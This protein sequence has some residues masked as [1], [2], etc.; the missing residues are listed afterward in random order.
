MGKKSKTRQVNHE[1]DSSVSPILELEFDEPIFTTAAHPSK[2]LILTGLATGHLYMSS[3][4]GEALEDAVETRR[5]TIKQGT[6]LKKTW[7]RFNVKDLDEDLVKVQ[8]K[9]KRHKGSCR[10]VAFDST[11]DN[12]Y[13]VGTDKVI[14]RANTETG[15]VIV[16]TDTIDMKQNFTK[17]ILAPNKP[18]V[19]VGSEAG[20]VHVFDTR[21]MKEVHKV[22][23]CHD[24]AVNSL[25]S[26]SAKSDYQYLSVGSTTLTHFDIR[27]GIIQQSED[28]EDEMLSVC[29]VDP[30]K[31]DTA[32]AGMG[33]G[34]VT[35]W[36]G[37][38]NDYV[39]QISRVRLGKDSVDCVIPSLDQEG[40]LV[41]AGS[42]NGLVSKIDTR[43]GKVVETRLHHLED[44]VSGLDIDYEYRLISNGMDKL[45]LWSVRS[46]ESDDDEEEEDESDF[47]LNDS[48]SE[49]QD[50]DEDSDLEPE[51][52]LKR[53]PEEPEEP[54]KKFKK[55]KL[56]GKQ[57]KNMQTH[58]HGIKKFD[59]L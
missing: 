24:D 10:S 31:C 26:M 27:K 53:E 37:E 36:K 25:T 42:A 6:K 29:F 52:P 17:L 4:Q 54:K 50:S 44:E 28:Q 47:D 40:D 15:K 18:V 30:S 3:Y 51:L 11:G 16:K 57:L 55:L 58:E 48:D 38:K 8:W 39:D 46:E 7:T 13:T 12:I 33:E 34:V 35:M 41:W 56:T 21:T 1:L 22:L 19:V 23:N 14:K 49:D 45:K 43:R 59:D 20:H 5:S 2:N 32:I 9:T